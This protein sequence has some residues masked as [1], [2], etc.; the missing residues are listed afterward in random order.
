MK[1]LLAITLG[2]PAGV[3][4]EL[5]A[6]CL[7]DPAL[8]ADA[9]FCVWGDPAVLH[10]ACEAAQVRLDPALVDRPEQTPDG[11]FGLIAV[12]Q[13]D[14]ATHAFG[15]PDPASGAGV[16]ATLTGAV[17]AAL[18]GA[19]HGLVTGPINKEFLSM[20]TGRPEGHTELLARL[21]N[22][23][24]AVMMLAGPTLRVVSLTSHAA[25]ADVPG[26]ITTE[27]IVRQARIVADGLRRYFCIARPRIAV[28]ALNPH[29]GEGGVY[30]TEEI[31]VIRPAVDRLLAEGIDATGPEPA[32]TVF[33]HAREGRCDAV[34]AMYHDQAMIPIKLLHFA[35]AVN[36]T[37]GLPILRTSPAHGTAYDLAGTGRASSASMK[38]AVRLATAM[39]KCR[40]PELQDG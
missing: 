27:G 18:T 2:D 16:L 17:E 14:A 5:A 13:A 15:K 34:I 38:S 10:A 40:F 23:P 6:R 36:V 33:L 24:Q 32:D 35:E 8:R 29:A 37:L 1:P 39:A 12:S 22:S 11:S 25:I 28:C 4:P 30:G 20:A 19:V 21:T 3:G 31:E 26:R 9:R 7:A